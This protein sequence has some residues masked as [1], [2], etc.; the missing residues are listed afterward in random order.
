MLDHYHNKARYPDP[1]PPVTAWSGWRRPG[2]TTGAWE[3]V[4]GADKP[5]KGQC[6]Q[7]LMGLSELVGG[8]TEWVYMILP[9]GERPPFAPGPGR[10]R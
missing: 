7:A 10:L 9:A 1:P 2:G 8:E 6:Y 3:R 5:T 4:P